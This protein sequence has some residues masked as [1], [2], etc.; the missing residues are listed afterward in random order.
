MDFNK[1]FVEILIAELLEYG[2][3]V[4][5]N[6]D[7]EKIKIQYFNFKKRLIEDIP[8]VVLKSKDFSCPP[9]HKIGLSLLE[10]KIEAGQSLKKHLSKNIDNLNYKDG[11]LNDWGIYHLHLGE[12]LDRDGFI[13]RTGPVLYARFDHENAYLISVMEHG[14]WTEQKM[15]KTI[16]E[17]WPDS[18]E[19]YKLKGVVG[20]SEKASNEDI[21]KLRGGGVN[22][23]IEVETG[24]VYMGPGGGFVSSKDS[25][26]VMRLVSMYNRIIKNLEEIVKANIEKISK[27]LV[28][29]FA[30]SGEKFIFNLGIKD[31]YCFAVE[32][33]SMVHFDLGKF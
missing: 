22:T 15:I 31:G 3:K 29:D 27:H 17:N 8:R 21:G 32:Q 19:S 4:D 7:S 12:N 23:A 11:L 26:E 10:K 14:N 2:I 18:I 33:N 13:S 9:Q 28:T 25:F 1:D 16:H 30:H 20:V 6:L 5:E 24:V